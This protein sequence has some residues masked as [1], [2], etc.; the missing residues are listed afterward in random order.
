MLLKEPFAFVVDFV[1]AVNQQIKIAAPGKRLS[2]TQRYWLG[3]CISA[4]MITNGVCWAWFERVS[5][6]HS[7]LSSLSWMFRRGKI[8]WEH[9]LIGSI[10]VL[11]TKYGISKGVLVLDD[12]DRSRSKS[13]THLAHIHKQKDK[14]TGGYVMGQNLVFLLFVTPK[15]TIPVG[16]AFYQPD[17]MKNTWKKENKRLKALGIPK[18]ERPAE[19]AKDPRY[20]TKQELGL[21][22]LQQ[23]KQAFKHIQID[24]ILADA[25]YGDANFMDK[26]SHIFD[27]IQ[28]I[29][30]LRQNQITKIQSKER[31]IRS[32]FK[33]YPGIPKNLP[34]RFGES[35]SVVL[36]GARLWIKAHHKK[37]YIVALRY[38]GEEEN[39]YLVATDMTWR[40][41]DI[42]AAYT[43]RW[44]V[45]V[46]FSDWKQYE[47]WCQMAKQTGV[48]GSNR[49][50]ILSLLTD[51]AL[52]LHPEQTAL[53]KHKLP[54]LTVGSLRDH[55]RFEA[56]IDFIRQIV[57]HDDPAAA[58]TECSEQIKKI[59]P[60]ASSNKHLNHRII[61]KLGSTASLRYRRAA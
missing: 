50:L 54:A 23:F 41:T 59:I 45:E 2:K 3:F 58:L 6:G 34:I 29:S 31:S 27:G 14:K 47:G 8:C 40:M 12:S 43:M 20:P 25:L 55:I 22:L 32:Y 13:T 5:L 56:I 37:R 7:K 49:G 15:I 19:P 11:L 46:F 28:V 42:A 57:D 53:L 30:Q 10:N 52:L 26:A 18:K 44:L 38:E 61:G 9:L 16:F 48:E 60:L 17:P 33:A 4:I 1:D 24:C 21:E 39:R 51:H 35:Q 36:G